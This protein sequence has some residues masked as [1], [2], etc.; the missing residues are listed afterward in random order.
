MC[1]TVY[2]EKKFFF[3]FRFKRI[4][5]L[6]QVF[7]SVQVIY[8]KNRQTFAFN[9]Q[10]T[11]F[12]TRRTMPF[13]H[14]ELPFKYSPQKD[15]Y[16]DCHVFAADDVPI[17]YKKGKGRKLA[18]INKVSQKDVTEKTKHTIYEYGCM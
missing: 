8:T 16:N 13:G 15:T 2:S 6:L 10:C 5:L 14:N 4:C 7:F 11:V 9:K 17:F 1:H 18:S 12:E 3:D